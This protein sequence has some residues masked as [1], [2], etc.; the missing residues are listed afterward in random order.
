MSTVKIAA[1]WT[2]VSTNDQRELSLDSQEDAVRK[3]LESKGYLVPGW[4]V[5]KVDWTSMDL[6]ACV[7]FQEL[8]RWIK[9]ERIQAVGVLERDRLQAQG[10][11]RLVFLSE[12]REH[13]VQMV[14]VQGVPMLEGARASWWS[15]PWPWGRRGPCPTGGPVTACGTGPC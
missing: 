3:V 5:L 13:N 10:L 9:E 12:C 6:V 14:T 11:Q 15:W 1:I 7:E 8:R 2:R 4:A